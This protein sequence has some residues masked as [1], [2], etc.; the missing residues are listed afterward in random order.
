MQPLIAVIKGKLGRFPNFDAALLKMIEHTTRATG[1]L[2]PVSLNW[3]LNP[4][5]GRNAAVADFLAGDSDCIIFLDDDQVFKSDLALR[6]A[7]VLEASP[8]AA[9]APLILKTEAPF[10]SVVW[11][12]EDGRLVPFSP[13]GKSGIHDAAEMGTGILGVRREVFEGSLPRPFFQ[14]G[15]I[16]GHPDEMMEDVF[17]TRNAHAAGYRLGVDVEHGAGHTAPYTVWP[18]V[19]NNCV[20]LADGRGH[21]L[22]IPAHNLRSMPLPQPAA[23]GL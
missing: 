19:L 20:V 14:L 21:S 5:K 10:Q 8:Y 22:A 9:V 3:G 15:Q 7:A 13:W 23:A 4:A 1:R 17:F 18:D 12:R 11:Q 2:L 16:P 6:L